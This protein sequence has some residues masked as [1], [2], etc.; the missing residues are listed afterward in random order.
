MNAIDIDPLLTGLRLGAIVLWAWVG[1]RVIFDSHE[2][3]AENEAVRRLGWVYFRS[4]IVVMSAIVVFI[5]SPADILVANGMIGAETR[6]IMSAAGVA[7][8]HL[9][10]TLLHLGLDVANHHSRRALPIY[11]VISYLFAAFAL[12]RG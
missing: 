1:L 11:L 2:I 8:L 10:A 4:S 5:F 3:T 9:S 12:A 7:G 6:K